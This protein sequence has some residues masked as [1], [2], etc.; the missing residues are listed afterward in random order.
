LRSR[1][2]GRGHVRRDIGRI[3]VVIDQ[4]S[5]RKDEIA[6]LGGEE[7]VDTGASD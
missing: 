1:R 4:R 7:I 6:A 5:Y 3:S 2:L